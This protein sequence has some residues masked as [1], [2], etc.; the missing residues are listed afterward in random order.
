MYFIII[1]KSTVIFY[2]FCFNFNYYYK[3]KDKIQ[4]DKFIFEY[5]DN[6]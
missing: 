4:L 2:K 3:K 6:F 5:L 1:N